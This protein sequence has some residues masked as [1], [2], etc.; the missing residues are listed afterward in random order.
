[1]KMDLK[2]L[3]INSL[4]LAIGV[5]LNQITPPILFGMKPDFSLAMLFIII[6]LNDDF[7]TCI[8]TGVVAG[9][10]AA[11]VTTFPGGQLPNIIDRIVTTSLVFIAVQPLK[12][13][14][15][16]KISI[17]LTSLVGTIISGSVFL[18]SAL[19]IVG[20][21]AS[22]KALFIT[23]VLPATIINAI[24]GTLIFIAVKKSMKVVFRR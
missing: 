5:V 16:D 23:V 9:L 21:P 12:N 2:K 17:I 10:L 18:G 20:L 3:I 15:N 6:L 19:V 14:M 8:L 24:V 4:F 22:F 11:A 7:K 13:K 1:M